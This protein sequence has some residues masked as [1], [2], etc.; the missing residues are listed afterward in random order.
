MAVY[1]SCV[2]LLTG[3]PRNHDLT[4][5]PTFY[6]RH[7]TGFQKD[8][9]EDP[10]ECIEV[11]TKASSSILYLRHESA[12]VRLSRP[13]GPKTVFKVFGS[14]Y[15]PSNGNW[16]FGYETA[17]A[18]A[19]WDQ[20]PRDTD[21]V[22]A[23]TPPYS[24]RD[25]R[26]TGGPVGCA[27]LR[28]VLQR[29]RPKLAVCG[30][31]HESRGYERVRWISASETDPAAKDQVVVVPGV[32]PSPGSKKQSLVDLTGKKAPRLDNVWS[33]AHGN[34]TTSRMKDRSLVS[35]SGS[36]SATDGNRLAMERRQMTEY[37]GGGD[38]DDS[39]HAIRARAQRQETCIVN[40]AIMGTSWPHRGG[41]RFNTPIVVDLELPMQKEL[42]L[43][44]GPGYDKQ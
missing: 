36:G 29:V 32:L 28:Q 13:D 12:V 5:D 27:A 10:Q 30:H 44:E 14:P 41:K 4:L 6:A 26:A 21:L 33:W 3:S 24:H 7:G 8:H 20:I 17:D 18:E 16:A 15:S 1:R 11:I 40:A 9:L 23:H 31:V 19:L 39:D 43:D 42:S 22:V 34:C 35:G 38:H 2:G 37:E 25:N